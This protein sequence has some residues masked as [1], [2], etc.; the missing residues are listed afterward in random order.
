MKNQFEDQLKAALLQREEEGAV[1]PNQ[2]HE[3]RFMLKL[4]QRKDK[5]RTVRLWLSIAAA[6]CIVGVVSILILNGTSP[7]NELASIEDVGLTDVTSR[8]TEVLE[9]LI[10]QSE[11][12]ANPGDQRIA[13]MLESLADLDQKSKMLDTLFRQNP[14]NENIAEAV[15]KNYEYRLQLVKQ[16][17]QYIEFQN[18]TNTH[19][20][21]KQIAS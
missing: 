4:S 21:E 10:K 18:R 19:H 11:V 16:L 7:N 1:M 6:A 8:K 5:G 2:G 3:E 12:P 15:V 17:K 13:Q 9:H 20:H 14:H